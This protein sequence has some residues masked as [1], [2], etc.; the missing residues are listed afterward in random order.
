MLIKDKIII[1]I[2]ETRDLEN[3]RK[4]RNDFLNTSQYL[5]YPLPINEKNQLSWFESISKSPDKIYFVIENEKNQFLGIIRA[6]EWDKIN[7]SI[8]TGMDL[9]PEFRS[10][11]LAYKTYLIFIEYLFNNININRIWLE[12]LD[13]NKYA[14]SLYK[15]IGF[16]EEGRKRQ[17]VYRHGEFCDYIVMSYLK[18][19]YE[20]NK[21]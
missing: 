15:K 11:G 16:I 10:K 6:D 7:Q 8:R 5:T 21:K 9:A 17:A 4:L 13:F 3:L 2:L 12:V 18:K 20:K 19:D 1:R 14:I